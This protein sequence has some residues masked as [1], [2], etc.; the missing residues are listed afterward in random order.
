MNMKKTIIIALLVL[1]ATITQAQRFEWA[2]GFE[3]N[4]YEIIGGL[5]DS[6]GNLYILSY[7]DASSSWEGEALIPSPVKGISK[8]LT[9]QVLIA[10]ISPEGEMVWKKIIVTNP[11][12]SNAPQD[13]KKVG[14][15]AFACLI[16]F[17]PPAD[18][19]TYYLDTL[20][21]GASDYPIDVHYFKTFGM[22]LYLVLDFDGNVVEQHFLCI[23]YTDADGND[24]CHY[25]MDTIP[26]RVGMFYEMPSFDL[27]GEGNIYISRRASDQYYDSEHNLCNIENGAIGG[28]KFWVDRRLAGEY[29]IEGSPKIWYPQL[30][31][32]SPHFDTLLACKYVVQKSVGE[33]ICSYSEEHSKLKLDHRGS[34][35]YMVQMH[36][37]NPLARNTIVIDSISDISVSHIDINGIFSFL[38]K[39]DTDFNAKWIIA[40]ED[41]NVSPTAFSSRTCFYDFDFDLDSNLLFLYAETGRGFNRDTVNFCSILTYQGTPLD[42]KNNTFFCAFDN[43]DTNPTIHSY[44]RVPEK[45]LASPNVMGK[46]GN[47]RIILHNQYGGGINFPSR[48][49]NLNSIYNN[50]FAMTVFDYSGRVIDG[51][52]YGIETILNNYAGPIIQHDSILYL[53]IL[54]R[55]NA[56]FGD[57][58]FYVTGSTNCIAKYVD[59][60]LMHPYVWNPAGIMGAQAEQPKVYPVPATDMLHFVVP[61]G[62]ATKAVAIS[63]LGNKT[64]LP[65]KGNSADV[66]A[67]APGTYILEISNGKTKYYS[68]F[69]KQ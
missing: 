61:Q 6:L 13:I 9:P 60:A 50:G 31:K 32:F 11:T 51:V 17:T 21:I 63:V 5:T 1:V 2:K 53:C 16:R 57:I 45:Y 55:S 44:N 49:I 40:F 39:Y 64:P 48:S 62:T 47:N 33:T 35:Y 20:I 66:S 46:S 26:W 10:K 24:I 7:I 65:T 4:G 34:I 29:R 22:T 54:L 25:S 30:L 56:R 15:S 52:D 28:L 3:T 69:V 18:G 67:L 43:N 23:T 14:D 12:G 41:D 19:Y 59:T 42:L 37:Y 68:K 27:D 58:D 36:P 8:D 38:V